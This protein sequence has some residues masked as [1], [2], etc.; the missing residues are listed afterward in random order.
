MAVLKFRIYW[1]D[2]ESVYRDVAITH[3]HH[4]FDFHE[5]I[6]KAFDFDNKHSA[7]FF[8]S[9]DNWQ[10]GRQISL[11]KYER[12][13]KAEPLIMNETVLGSEVHE[14]NQKFLYVYDFHKNWTFMVELIHINKE[15]DR[16]MQYPSVIRTEGIAPSQYGTKGLVNEKLAEIEEKYDLNNSVLGDKNRDEEESSDESEEVSEEEED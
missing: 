10:R 16:T 6:L 5:A 2:D 9:N 12:V 7:T 1:D 13:Y 11:E 4:F 14:P 15:E 3:Q 8:R